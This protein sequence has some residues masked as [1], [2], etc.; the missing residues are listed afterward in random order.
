M[1]LRTDPWLIVGLILSI[2]LMAYNTVQDFRREHGR[3]PPSAVPE[4]E[5][6]D[7]DSTGNPQ[8]AEPLEQNPPF[9]PDRV[10]GVRGGG[11]TVVP[12]APLMLTAEARRA[13]CTS[14]GGVWGGPECPT[15]ETLS[16]KRPCSR[17]GGG[18]ETRPRA[19]KPVLGP[20]DASKSA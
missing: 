11:G 17:I 15:R 7:Q 9:V 13:D 19:R 5:I 1:K 8:G 20:P 4:V 2:L 18:A 10:G 12:P 3:V 14:W 16:T 6:P